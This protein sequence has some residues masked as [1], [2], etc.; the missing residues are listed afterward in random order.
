[1]NS[2]EKLNFDVCAIKGEEL[3]DERKRGIVEKLDNSDSQTK[4]TGGG[5][6]EVYIGEKSSKQ[7]GK[8]V[9]GVQRLKNEADKPKR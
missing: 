3:Q 2:L 5:L 6:K 8:S 1:L 9:N 7:G 4:K